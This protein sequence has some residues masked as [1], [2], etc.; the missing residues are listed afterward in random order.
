[1]GF[2]DKDLE[3]LFQRVETEFLKYQ[4]SK[5]S[6]MQAGQPVLTCDKANLLKLWKRRESKA[7]N[8]ERNMARS[9]R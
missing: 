6:N 1:M 2:T 4:G 8:D 7:N 3:R 9:I 5:Y